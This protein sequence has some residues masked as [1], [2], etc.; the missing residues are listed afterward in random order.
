[1]SQKTFSSPQE[2]VVYEAKRYKGDQKLLD[3]REQAI[4]AGFLSTV[5]GGRRDLEALDVPCGYGRFSNALLSVSSRLVD[6]DR[7]ENMASR[8]TARGRELGAKDVAG[9]GVDLV[10]LP[11]PD[12]A[13]DVILSMRLLHHIGDPAVRALMFRE[14]SRV[15]RKW[16]ITS[17]YD[18]NP[19]HQLQRGLSKLTNAKRRKSK[20]YFYPATTF[21]AEVEAAGFTVRE[22]VVPVRFVHAQ[23]L[24]LLEKRS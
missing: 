14:L 7:S 22:L 3:R 16:V 11:F 9:V 19:L 21:R 8:A 20:I 1:M 18:T 2:V 13:F 24:A 12:R 5:S 4:I 17:F 6:A 15:T 10:A 23:R